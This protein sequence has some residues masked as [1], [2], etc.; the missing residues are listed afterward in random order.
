MEWK[1]ISRNEEKKYGAFWKTRGKKIDHIVNPQESKKELN[2]KSKKRQRKY[3]ALS[4]KDKPQLP[5]LSLEAA[6]FPSC[7]TLSCGGCV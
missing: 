3:G 6:L 7:L 5:S 2:V 4:S 1:R